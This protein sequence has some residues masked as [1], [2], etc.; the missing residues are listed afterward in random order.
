M[1]S[2]AKSRLTYLYKE[3]EHPPALLESVALIVCFLP[4]PFAII[5]GFLLLYFAPPPPPIFMIDPILAHK[6][7]RAFL[8]LLCLVIYSVFGVLAIQG[9]RVAYRLRNGEARY[10]EN[11][12]AGIQK[13][14]DKLKKKFP[15]LV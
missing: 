5:G 11:Y 14:I 15:R 2:V 1:E 13:Q 8:V 10:H 9:I 7:G 3:L 6:I 4:I 12:R